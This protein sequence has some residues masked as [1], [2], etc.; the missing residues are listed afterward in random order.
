MQGQNRD[1]RDKGVTQLFINGES[2]A[3]DDGEV[4]DLIEPETETVSATVA[5]GGPADVT[6]AVRSSREAATE[7]TGL[8][9]TERSRLLYGFAQ[10]IQDET[11]RLAQ[12]E[13]CD[14]GKP[15]SAAEDDVESLARYFEYY[16]G[17]ADKING[18]TV[19]AGENYV[20]YTRREPVGVTGHILPW[21]FPLL[22]L[23]R[24]VAPSL[25]AGNTVVVKPAEETPRTAIE[26]AK[27][28]VDAGFPPGVLN[29]VTGCGGEAGS[30]LAGHDGIDC[31]SFTGSVPTGIEVGR[32]AIENVNPVHLELGGNGPNVVFPD[33]NFENAVENALLA[34]F[35]N[36]GQVCSAGPRLLVH[37]AIHDKFVNELVEQA[38]ALTLG[39]VMDDPD[40]GPVISETQYERVLN[41]IDG[42]KEEIGEPVIGGRPL[43][44]SGYFVEPTI[45]DGVNNDA[46]IAQEEV[47]GPVL[48]VTTFEDESAAIAL[49]N[50]TD[51]GLT[52]G[53]FTENGGRAHRFARDVEAGVVFLNEWFAPGVESP[54]GGYKD[55][56]IGREAGLEAIDGYTQ[57]KSVTGRIDK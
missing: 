8:S 42:A 21:N 32:A 6:R 43:D 22:L 19:S 20:G 50:D 14:A 54:F 25:A 37:E 13:A 57:T 41:Y 44:Q 28:A 18:E 9:T 24:S 56:G 40:M 7:W 1:D 52:A 45:F 51:Y 10:A 46:R 12:L 17:V 23:G 33:A 5:V 55:S 11:S 2:V 3:P 48:T 53:V 49:A 31:I 35:L 4:F 29:V 39:P 16:A 36:A 15:I 27:L 47:F 30:A 26:T 34:A 38:A